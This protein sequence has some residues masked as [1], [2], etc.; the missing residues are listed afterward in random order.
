LGV[1]RR[2]GARDYRNGNRIHYTNFE[3]SKQEEGQVMSNA[4]PALSKGQTA[5]AEAIIVAH[6]V[7]TSTGVQAPSHELIELAE[8]ILDGEPDGFGP[9]GDEPI[10][11]FGTQLADIDWLNVVADHAR[12]TGRN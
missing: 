10:P 7:L 9:E 12:K 11:Y 1:S 5:R 2:D 3:R 6:N 8:Y 4:T